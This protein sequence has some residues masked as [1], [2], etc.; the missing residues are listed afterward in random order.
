[1]Q[2]EQL[3]TSDMNKG[4]ERRLCVIPTSSLHL[5]KEGPLPFAVNANEGSA[6]CH[7]RFPAKIARWSARGP[8]QRSLTTVGM[9]RKSY[10]AA[11]WECASSQTSK[12]CIDTELC[13]TRDSNSPAPRLKFAL[14]NFQQISIPPRL[15]IGA[16]RYFCQDFSIQILYEK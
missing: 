8:L 13:D 3:I 9:T 14:S 15:S 16:K 12:L 1:M 5:L 11:Q 7:F 4:G 6:L 2:E 10:L